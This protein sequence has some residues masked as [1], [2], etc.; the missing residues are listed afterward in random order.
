MPVLHTDP[1]SGTTAPASGTTASAPPELPE[2]WHYTEDLVWEEPYSSSERR[3]L[4][5]P[6]LIVALVVAVAIGLVV[7]NAAMHYSRGV[8]ALED[9]S[10]AQAAAELSSAS[11][12]ILPYRD[13]EPLA[14]QARRYLVVEAAGQTEAQAR[15][16]LVTVALGEA[17]AAFAA[18]DGAGDAA[19]VLTALRSPSADDLRKVLRDEP[20]AREMAAAL[21]SDL[22]AAARDALRALKWDRAGG[23]AA[24]LLVLE[25]SSAEATALAAKAATGEELSARLAKARDAARRGNWRKALRL[26]LG[27]TAVREGFPGAASV[28]ADARRALAPKPKP[29]P[30]PAAAAATTTTTPATTTGGTSSGTSS[31]PPPP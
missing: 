26:A 31:Q 21:T 16:K 27:V 9:H 13:A 2:G 28:I 8:A 11:L 6:A 23:F 17:T 1:A 7:L 15:V 4:W 3:R 19:E 20:G 12:L 29:S 10:Y 14:D 24:A 5:L 22:T 30:A 18:A 25:P